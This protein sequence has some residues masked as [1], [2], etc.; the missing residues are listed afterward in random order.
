MIRAIIIFLTILLPV[1]FNIAE[2]NFNDPDFKKENFSINFNSAG[3]NLFEIKLYLPRASFVKLTVSDEKNKTVKT[4]LNE[5]IKSGNYELTFNANDL[6][7]G[8][9]KLNF[10]AKNYSEVKEFRIE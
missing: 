4:L 1:N 2:P 3:K 7:K 5:N 6:K 9:Y 10:K 8:N